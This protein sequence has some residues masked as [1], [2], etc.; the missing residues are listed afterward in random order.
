M[1]DAHDNA[2]AD[3]LQLR[4]I[5]VHHL[6]KPYRKHTC[7]FCDSKL[8]PQRGTK[9]SDGFYN[10]EVGEWWSKTREISVLGHPDCLPEGCE[11]TLNPNID[12]EWSMA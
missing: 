7:H 12:T 9:L 4:Y 5:Q 11:D 2:I 8:R 3:K 1:N 10:E 6:D